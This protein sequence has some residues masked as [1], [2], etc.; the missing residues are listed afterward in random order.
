M[1]YHR[2][3]I[4][5]L[6][7]ALTTT[8]VLFT[9]CAQPPEATEPESGTESGENQA[10]TD[11]RLDFI[12]ADRD[13]PVWL[14]PLLEKSGD[15]I[16]NNRL[17]FDRLF[18]FDEKAQPV[19]QLAEGYEVSENGKTYTVTIKKNVT[20]HDGE[21]FTADDVVFTYEKAIDPTVACRYASD[22]WALAGYDEL[23]DEAN[24]KTIDQL[25]TKPV[26]AVD[27]YTVQFN[28]ETPYAPFVSNVL[29]STAI[30]PKH[31]LED[32][33]DMTEAEF[34]QHPIGTGPF[35]FKEWERD[36]HI[37]LVAYDDYY[38]GRPKVKT[39]TNRLIPDAAVG[40]MEL[41]SGGIHYRPTAKLENYQM[42]KDDP[43]F[44]TLSEVGFSYST[45]S[46][47]NDRKPWSDRRVREAIA[48]GINLKEAVDKYVGDL[49]MMLGTPIPPS[50]WAHNPNLKP[51]PFDQD[52]A[53]E[54]LEEAGWQLDDD[55][56]LK[57]ADGDTFHF[58]LE[59]FN[60]VER[61][62]MNV[63]FQENLRHLG[64]EV[65][66]HEL[67]TA[68]LLNKMHQAE[69]SDGIFITWGMSK[70][71]DAEMFRRFHSSEMDWNN[72]YHY[73]NPE[74]DSLL[75]QARHELDQAKRKQMYFKI[76]EIL[77][78]DV[79]GI[80]AFTKKYTAAYTPRLKGIKWGADGWF[81]YAHLIEL[82]P[83]R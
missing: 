33:E 6:V 57:N 41:K 69:H 37:T 13:D 52:K 55:G 10:P 66:C 25:E 49:G 40:A 60:G 73:S 19:P 77:Q 63:I 75:E 47:V 43:A 22:M 59:T 16:R 5:V 76:Q 48:Y 18:I 7:V 53:M 71:P 28:L 45:L 31:L 61:A 51:R 29:T 11:E 3:W 1:R 12:W 50:S 36:D 56:L 80:F 78:E 35:A 9:G 82:E 26:V 23:T 70:D 39:I 83:E 17:V 64:M 62:D 20:W 79:P 74:V 15:D 67:A 44:E 14:N 38:Q 2:R 46:F 24:P 81:D 21:P 34:N 72:F 30:V 42:F 8:L 58:A 4:V 54:L 65:E 27:E 68:D 32:E